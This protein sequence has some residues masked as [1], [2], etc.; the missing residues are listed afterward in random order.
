VYAFN[1]S[2]HSIPPE[3]VVGSIASM[4]QRTL[5]NAWEDV[6]FLAFKKRVSDKVFT[7]ELD[8]AAQQQRMLGES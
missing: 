1:E 6:F 7:E 8:Y 4:Q 5:R 3:E 2:I